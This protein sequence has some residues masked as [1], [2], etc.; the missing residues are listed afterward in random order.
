MED[1][2]GLPG[3]HFS[4]Q[5]AL[6]LFKKAQS[7]EDFEKMLNS[8]DNSVNNLDLNQDGEI[9]YLKIEDH[10][11]KDAHAIV[12]QAI[13]NEKESQ[14]VAVIE[15]EK[16]GE[17]SA[18]L[19]I[20]GDEDLYGEATIVE[21]FEEDESGDK[22]KNHGPNVFEP[23]LIRVV[24]NV[25]PWSI[26]RFAYA[27]N[28]VRWVSPWRWRHYPVWWRPWRPHPLYRIYP[29]RVHYYRGIHIVPTRRVARAHAV[30]TPVR[31]SSVT[32]TRTHSKSVTTYRA[33]K[34]VQV[35]RNT[36]KV[37]RTGPRGNQ[38][39]TK[40]TKTTVEGPKGNKVERTSRKTTRTR[41]K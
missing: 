34:K 37:E 3:D 31:R 23:Q 17:A 27:P 30:Y 18:I 29:M 12:I 4:L 22:E 13:I 7:M 32:V 10:L 36:Q 35:T 24:V 33:N 2:T 40:K 6:D 8:E 9:D 5:G 19:Q 25:W 14:D 41:K 11:K 39:T 21:P 28:Y 15:L 38:V 20:I 1:S 16:N 26:V